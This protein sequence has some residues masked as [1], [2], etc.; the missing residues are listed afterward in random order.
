M[1][2]LTNSQDLQCD[3]SKSIFPTPTKIIH[4]LLLKLSSLLD[5]LLNVHPTKFLP[6]KSPNLDLNNASLPLLLVEASAPVT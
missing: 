6:V 2:H 1:I 4:K 5:H 3:Q